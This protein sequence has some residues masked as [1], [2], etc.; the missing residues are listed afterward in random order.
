M[1]KCMFFLIIAA[2]L[3]M[4]SVGWSAKGHNMVAQIASRLLDEDIRQ[5]VNEYLDGT[6]WNEASVWMDKVRPHRNFKHMNGWHFI[7]REKNEA[8]DPEATGNIVSELQRVIG[9]LKNRDQLTKAEIRTNLLILFHLVGDLH[10]PLHVGYGSDKGGNNRKVLLLGK[11]TNL[12]KLWDDNIIRFYSLSTSHCMSLYNRMEENEIEEIRQ[13]DVVDWM[14][15][16]RSLLPAVY[17]F[18]SGKISDAYLQR[19]KE[20]IKKQLLKGGIRLA[21]VLEDIFGP[22]A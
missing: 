6:S 8:F 3:P 11:E 15:D 17:N 13:V 22:E 18:R 14:E 7:N 12:H 5:Q 19:N 21:K 10:Q 1:K 16:S 20:V 4:Y 2:I 9:E